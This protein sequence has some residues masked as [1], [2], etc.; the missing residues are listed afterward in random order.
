MSMQVR[1]MCRCCKWKQ[2]KLTAFVSKRCCQL[3]GPEFMEALLDGSENA[4]ADDGD[5][6]D[7]DGSQGRKGA[8]SHKRK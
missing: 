4:D 6:A 8:G 7:D 1:V 5:D 3:V 2:K